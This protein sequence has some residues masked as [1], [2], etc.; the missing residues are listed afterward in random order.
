MVSKDSLH[1]ASATGTLGEAVTKFLISLSPEKRLFAQQEVS[2]FVRW[3]GEERRIADLS[4]PEVE[5]YSE[6]ITCTTTE[7]AEKL[8]P[9]KS[10]LSFCHKQG[11]TK[12]KLS[13]H[14]K[15]KKTAS[16]LPHASR[17][18][19]PRKVALTPQGYAELE[20]ELLSLKEQRPRIIEEI[21]KAA[22]DK[23]FRENA[24][25]DAAKDYQGQ[26]EARIKE[27]ESMLKE[28]SVIVNQQ[29]VSQCI[30][31]GDTVVI[32]DLTTGERM[33]YK[34]VDPSEANPM[35][36][37][38]SNISPIG[39]A[40]LGHSKGDEVQVIAP[41]GILPHKIEDVIKRS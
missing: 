2:K 37:K 6:Q 9:V 3:Y 21:Q 1:T 26:V 14:I 35:K 12:K 40:L 22:A 17:K 15:V 11:F 27:L 41:V 4:V 10:F 28:A 34:I 25:L 38:I 16:S 13:A 7:I 32:C 39:K 20:S 19:A 5:N 36:G 30:S 29:E 18:P 8:E 23:D 24:P 33:E 31:M